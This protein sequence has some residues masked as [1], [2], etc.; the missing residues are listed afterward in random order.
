MKFK[1]GYESTC[2]IVYSHLKIAEIKKNTIK[3]ADS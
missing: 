1:I 3:G 2:K